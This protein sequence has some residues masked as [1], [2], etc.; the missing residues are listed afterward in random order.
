[1]L[2][3]TPAGLMKL[4]FSINDIIIDLKQAIYA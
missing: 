3:K 4:Q 1:M 2:E